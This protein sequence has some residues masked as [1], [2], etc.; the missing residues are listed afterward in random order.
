MVDAD[1]VR[2][3]D[4]ALA[5]RYGDNRWP[6]RSDPLAGLVKTI[7]SQSTTSRNSNAAFEALV[8]QFPAWEQVAAASVEDIA[9]AIY[10][11]GLANQK[12][13][14]IKAILAQIQGE[15]GELSLG[16]LDELP[17]EQATEYLRSFTGV[18]PKTAACVLMFDL[19]KPVFP[20]DTHVLRITG[21]LG[22]IEEGETAERAHG[23]LANL[24]APERRY[25]L[26]V[27]LV[28]HGRTLCHARGPQC[29]RCPV[30]TYCPWGMGG[31]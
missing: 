8:E 1:S 16:F 11:G 27:N 3:V 30:E 22:W 4:E 23:L 15:R 20:V 2:A 21:R 18:G 28:A 29:G 17:V 10:E 13:G 12:A 14:R 5:A 19:G 9:A 24:I 6:G 26:H 31:R 7:L 25:R